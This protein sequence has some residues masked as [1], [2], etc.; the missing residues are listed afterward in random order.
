MIEVSKDR[1]GERLWCG[2]TKVVGNDCIY[3]GC[4]NEH[5]CGRTNSQGAWVRD[6]WC[7]TNYN[8]GC[9]DK[10]S[11]DYQVVACCDEPKFH[12]IKRGQYHK[13]CLNCRARLPVEIVRIILQDRELQEE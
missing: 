2:P 12:P 7:A 4:F 5:D 9:P 11:E 1:Y 13:V 8:K 10:D 3:R 6:S